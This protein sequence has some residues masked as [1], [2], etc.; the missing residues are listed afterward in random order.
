LFNG[1]AAIG[2]LFYHAVGELLYLLE[3]VAALLAQV[4]VKWHVFFMKFRKKN[5]A[6]FLLPEHDSRS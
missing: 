5:L 2:T 3:A 4:L 1:A 6:C